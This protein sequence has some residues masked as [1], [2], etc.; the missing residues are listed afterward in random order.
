VTSL[1]LKSTASETLTIKGRTSR[2]VS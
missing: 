1:K 2:I